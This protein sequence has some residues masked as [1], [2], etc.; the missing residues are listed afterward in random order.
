MSIE[1]MKLKDEEDDDD[2]ALLSQV[3]NCAVSL[4]TTATVT[5]FKKKKY[6]NSNG[7]LLASVPIQKINKGRDNNT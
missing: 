4:H 3:P 7:S 6:L 2:D 1:K 5:I